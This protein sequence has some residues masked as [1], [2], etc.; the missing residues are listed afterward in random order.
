LEAYLQDGKLS[1][2]CDGVPVLPLEKA[3]E[4]AENIFIARLRNIICTGAIGL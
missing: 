4:L 1:Q 2:R 3:I